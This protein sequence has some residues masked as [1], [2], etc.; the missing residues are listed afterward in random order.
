[1]AGGTLRPRW[2][3]VASEQ[4]ATGRTAYTRIAFDRNNGWTGTDRDGTPI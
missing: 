3:M 2:T 1:M 4:T